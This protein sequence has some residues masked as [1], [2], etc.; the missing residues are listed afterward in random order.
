MTWRVVRAVTF[1]AHTG[2]PGSVVGV[3]ALVAATLGVAS[4][5]GVEDGAL[6]AV[7]MTARH[8]TAAVT[9][10][11][12]DHMSAMVAP[13]SLQGHECA[14]AAAAMVF[15]DGSHPGPAQL[16][17]AATC[18]M[19]PSASGGCASCRMKVDPELGS[20]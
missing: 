1:D 13:T 5:L 4:G 17:C 3:D 14:T 2:D 6:H 20:A 12:R 8:A 10:D 11:Q 19:T 18:P 16:V 7:D 15:L 9:S